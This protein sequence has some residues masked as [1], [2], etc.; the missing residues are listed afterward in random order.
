MYAVVSDNLGR[1]RI[2]NVWDNRVE[3]TLG[4][5]EEGKADKKWA[6]GALLLETQN[7]CICIHDSGYASFFEFADNHT[8]EGHAE[9]TKIL[10]IGNEA[11]SFSLKLLE[12]GKYVACYDGYIS[13]FTKDEVIKTFE[14][15]S[16]AS[17]ASSFG[18]TA[19]YGR[20]NDSTLVYDIETGKEIWKSSIPP[21]DYLKLRI[22][23]IDHSI[24]F[25]DEN[26]FIVGQT[27][28]KFIIYDIRQGNRPIYRSKKVLEEFPVV[29]MSMLTED[30]LVVG[31]TSGFMRLCNIE[32]GDEPAEIKQDEDLTYTEENEISPVLKEREGKYFKALV[33]GNTYVGMTGGITGFSKHKNLEL[34]VIICYDRICRLF[35]IAKTYKVAKK[36]SYTKTLPT[37]IALF[38]DEMPNE[39]PD[40]MAWSMLDEEDANIWDNYKP[41]PQAKMTDKE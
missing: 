36:E 6:I 3:H 32:F 10:K 20:F 29:R 15:I 12:E 2:L 28:G 26:T 38:D 7:S 14:T 40:E 37:D 4:G 24:A 30:K 8:Q 33:E 35:D 16:G 41:C 5:D 11:K 31:D 21:M 34:L 25:I 18:R 1:L 22:K 19:A 17:T 39:D 13:V 9:R 23:D 27:L